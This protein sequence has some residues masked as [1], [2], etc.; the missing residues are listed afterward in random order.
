M[1]KTNAAAALCLAALLGSAAADASTAGHAGSTLRL[2]GGGAF[3]MAR[4]GS[5]KAAAKPTTP[6]WYNGDLDGNGALGLL[7][8]SV[9]PALVATGVS[10]ATQKFANGGSNG[11]AKSPRGQITVEQVRLARD[12]WISAVQRLSV[13]ETVALYDTANVR[14][15][16]T[17]DTE[18]N[19]LRNS[20]KLIHEYFTHFLA[21]DQIVA[22]FP[23]V[24]ED[25][26]IRLGKD[27][28]IYSGY[29]TFE[30]T[31]DGV[32][33]AAKAKFSYVYV[34]KPGMPHL[35]ISTHNSGITPQGVTVIAKKKFGGA[36]PP[37]PITVAEVTAARDAWVQAVQNLDVD[38]TTKLYDTDNVRLLGT[39]D[40]E[41]NKLRNNHALIHEYFVHFLS[42]DKIVAKFPEVTD[43]NII[44]LGPNHVIFSD[45][46]TFE[47]TKDGKTRMAKA[48]FSYVYRRK[49]GHQ[50]LLIATHNSGITPEGIVE[51]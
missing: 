13:S 2:R 40:T 48:K 5:L 45:Y 23:E 3:S 9:L 11:V 49:A 20:H 27:H 43:D 31:K 47:L 25:S 19:K 33:K 7:G 12:M 26:I 8:S 39:V 50:G 6:S 1:A 32:T 34:R 4:P 42:N 28:V 15:L 41:D 36:P 37:P 35:L 21:H 30:L 10:I 24:T 22:N 51:M 16:G 46:Y 38:A 29:Y 44:Q 14:L 17:V 18:D